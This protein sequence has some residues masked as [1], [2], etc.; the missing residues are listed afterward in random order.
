MSLLN[1]T[2]RRA[3]LVRPQTTNSNTYVTLK[4]QHVKS[5]TL[6]VTGP[7][8]S[9]EQDFLFEI[10]NYDSGLLLEVWDKGMLWDK[11]IGYCWTPL[12]TFQFSRMP[13]F[14]KTVITQ[15]SADM[16]THNIRNNNLFFR[17][18]KDSF[19]YS[20]LAQSD[21][22]NIPKNNLS[23][24][25]KGGED[26]K[27]GIIDSSRQSTEFNY[28]NGYGKENWGVPCT[29]YGYDYEGWYQDEYG[30]WHV[31]PYYYHHPEG[32]YTQEPEE[33]EPT[34][35]F[36]RSKD[37]RTIQIRIE[38]VSKFKVVRN[39]IGF[40]KT[41]ENSMSGGKEIVDLNHKNVINSSVPVD[42]E[43]IPYGEEGTE[44]YE[45][46]WYQ[47]EYGDCSLSRPNNYDEGWYQDEESGEWYNQ[48]DWHQDE[49]GEWYY[50]DRSQDYDGYYQDSNGDWKKI[51]EE[52]IPNG[53]AIK[54]FDSALPLEDKVDG[55]A[56]GGGTSSS[57]FKG[58]S[59]IG[60]E[61]KP[62]DPPVV[63]EE[64]STKKLPPRPA[65]YDYYWYQDDE[66]NWWNE[67]ND[68]GYEFDPNEYEKD[69]ALAQEN[70]DKPSEPVPSKTE[71]KDEKLSST[72]KNDNIPEEKENLV[73]DQ[74]I[75]TK[76]LPPR[77][78]DYDYYWYKDDDGNWRNEYD[79][80]GYEFDPNEY[81]ETP[82][83]P[84]LGEK[85]NEEEEFYTEEE[86]AQGEKE[87]LEKENEDE[88][89]CRKVCDNEPLDVV[90]EEPEA[91][92]SINKQQKRVSFDNKSR[93][94]SV[95]HQWQ[96]AF[97]KVVQMN[98]ALE[99]MRITG[100]VSTLGNEDYGYWDENG[101]W[102]EYQGYYDEDGYWIDTTEE[103]EEK[104][105]SSN[106]ST[107]PKEPPPPPPV[108]VPPPP[109]KENDIKIPNEAKTAANEAKA[110]AAEAKAAADEAAKVA[111]EASKNIMKGISSFGGGLLSGSSDN[112]KGGE[113]K[114]FG[115]FWL[116]IFLVKFSKI[117]G[118]FRRV[119]GSKKFHPRK[120]TPSA[121]SPPLKPPT[122]SSEKPKESK[123]PEPKGKPA[124]EVI[125]KTGEKS[126]EK[127]HAFA[128]SDEL[129]VD[130]EDDQLFKP[131]THWMTPKREMAM[132]FWN[133]NQGKR[134]SK[135]INWLTRQGFSPEQIDE[136]LAEEEYMEAA[137]KEGGY[138]DENGDWIDL[139]PENPSPH[140]DKDLL[141]PS[142]GLDGESAAP[143]STL[144]GLSTISEEGTKRVRKEMR[145]QP[146]ASL[147]SAPPGDNKPK[148]VKHINKT[149]TMSGKQKWE[150]AFEKIIQLVE[151]G[152]FNLQLDNY[153]IQVFFTK[154]AS[155]PNVLPRPLPIP[156]PLHTQQ[157]NTSN[158]PFLEEQV[159]LLAEKMEGL[160]G[161]LRYAW[162]AL[163]VLSQE[164]VKMWQR[165]EKME[166]LL[167]EQQTD[168]LSRPGSP[169]LLIPDENF[170]KALN[171]VHGEANSDMR[172]ALSQDGSNDEEIE[173]LNGVRPTYL[174]TESP[175]ASK[176][177]TFADFY[178][179]ESN[180]QDLIKKLSKKQ[181]K[182]K[183][184]ETTDDDDYS[185]EMDGKSVTTSSRST[186]SGQTHKSDEGIIDHPE[187][188]CT[189]P[190]VY[191]NIT[192]PPHP[193][194]PKE[195]E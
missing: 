18:N 176:T 108:S 19:R 71:E 122:A 53:T 190:G 22:R 30:E 45:E 54:A 134:A 69:P 91:E 170:Y 24:L 62:E 100:E 41:L 9:W 140:P 76:K 81:E 75:S 28:I 79:D 34:S 5:T 133:D 135:E 21:K 141:A 35:P 107:T 177:G 12:S 95:R 50:E 195:I 2:V 72:N 39:S 61:T 57:I 113:K 4:L 120:E 42:S 157:P 37:V 167:S 33:E 166:G 192:P 183:K 25:V 97:T 124:E 60:A 70:K 109:Q 147:G 125:I 126:E 121:S 130:E 77:P 88:L 110:A 26:T 148:F 161:E 159:E 160:E 185:E 103:V 173:S 180:S 96:W 154:P 191:D 102:I 13:A 182:K 1:V 55:D 32:Y 29:S 84:I 68:L 169:P 56:S 73:T 174:P 67:Y 139:I 145:G 189:S 188:V 11:A 179:G 114:L 181:S 86:I 82:P 74:P 104:P 151:E 165:L 85:T 137:R 14:L 65:D 106:S 171:Q 111:A 63:T 155:V 136:V 87:L 80:N 168:E 162:R 49:S 58:L 83:P 23:H 78:S 142:Q 16:T 48:F 94:D 132:V 143:T 117:I 186:Q 17:K 149:R 98:R 99:Y 40:M 144:Q 172:L 92:E 47:D 146:P 116:W 153:Y 44:Y 128:A 10:D 8:P 193:R 163:D 59:S 118:W 31:D 52:Q 38:E 127:R 90:Y 93:V 164:Y 187:E 6:T 66:G 15:E 27:D 105:S 194:P 175:K 46:G 51:E 178:N 7:Q 131:F 123:G 36:L 43:Y 20:Q 156:P 3:N 89:L 184:A 152:L 101:V 119:L 64:T 112:K 129:E 150:W 138:F 158:D 115:W